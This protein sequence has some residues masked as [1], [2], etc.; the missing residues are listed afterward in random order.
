MVSG[1]RNLRG[2]ARIG[3]KTSEYS[4]GVCSQKPTKVYVSDKRLE[5]DYIVMNF[6]PVTTY[7]DEN[8][9]EKSTPEELEKQ[10]KADRDVYAFR[11]EGVQKM[12]R[13]QRR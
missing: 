8:L 12:K 4:D 11:Q 2:G 13:R 5:R 6:A 1:R 9:I 10:R 7:I 3:L